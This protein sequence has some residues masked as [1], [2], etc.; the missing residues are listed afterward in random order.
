MI[1]VTAGEDYLDI[2]A[3]AGIVAY[4]ELLRLDGFKAVAASDAILNASVPEFLASLEMGL[5]RK[6]KPKKADT[7]VMI[8]LSDPK[9]FSKFV[10]EE[11]VVEILDHH[12]GFEDYWQ[13]KLGKK[14]KIEYVGAAC[15]L[16]Y[17]AWRNA[18]LL[19]QMPIDIAKLLLAGILDNT[20]NLQAVITSPRDIAAYDK[21]QKLAG[22]DEGFTKKYFEACQAGAE[23][24][25]DATLQNDFKVVNYETFAPGPIAIGQVAVWDG[26]S[27]VNKFSEQMQHFLSHKSEH[28]IMNILSIADGQSMFVASDPATID[29]IETTLGASFEK[30]VSGL[31][32]AKAGRFWLRKEIHKADLEKSK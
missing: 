13:A 8:D 27:I 12:L 31:S 29:W 30:R 6:Y 19:D 20:L 14:S 5:V 16:V 2:D 28:W 18:G 7:F 32:V 15:T 10:R 24:T 25:F 1:V 9:H 3:Y 21:L 26:A 4:A 23:L 11:A 22:V 17:E